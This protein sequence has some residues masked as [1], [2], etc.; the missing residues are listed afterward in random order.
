VGNGVFRLV[1]FN[2]TK[3]CGAD[4]I[5]NNPGGEM[6]K[7]V[8]YELLSLDGVA[9][10]PDDFI[11]DFDDVMMENLLRVIATQDAVLLGRR[12]Y[13]EW[14]QYWQTRNTP[15]AGF[16]NGTQ[17]F[18]VTSKPMLH[19]WTNTTV[20][21]GDLI[22]FVTELKQKPGGD[23]GVH[24]SIT[25]AQSLLEVGLVDELRLVIAPSIQMQGRKLF[26]KGITKR[27]SL[28]RTVTSPSGY[29]LVDFQFGS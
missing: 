29:L 3:P 2:Q 24:G 20:I 22:K 7:I 18:A 11:T 15:F 12:T 17:K 8:A 13:D 4:G 14:A 23:I 26:E 6:R 21:A 16:I 28:S 5:H 19:N 27:L 9:E 1:E 25:L 10:R